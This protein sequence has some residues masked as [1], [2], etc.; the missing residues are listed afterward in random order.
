MLRQKGDITM[1]VYYARE[2]G[3]TTSSYTEAFEWYRS[4]LT[5]MTYT[6]E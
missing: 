3:W 4:G 1:V 6:F 5:V 2:K